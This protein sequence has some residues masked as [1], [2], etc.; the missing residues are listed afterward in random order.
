VPSSESSCVFSC[1]LLCNFWRAAMCVQ[2]LDP[3]GVGGPSLID[4]HPSVRQPHTACMYGTCSHPSQSCPLSIRFSTR[5]RRQERRPHAHQPQPG[6][7][8][9]AGGAPASAGLR[10]SEPV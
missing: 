1:A 4:C 9:S 7:L 8:C 2:A 6:A 3:C 5:P 10:G